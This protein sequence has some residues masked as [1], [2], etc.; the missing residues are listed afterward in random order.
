MHWREL[1]NW[2]AAEKIVLEGRERKVKQD[3]KFICSKKGEEGIGQSRTHNGVGFDIDHKD[4]LFNIFQ[5]LHRSD[6]FSGAG[7]GLA[8]VRRMIEKHG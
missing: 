2:L 6:D 7:V 8:I 1:E 4:K 3:A 5:R